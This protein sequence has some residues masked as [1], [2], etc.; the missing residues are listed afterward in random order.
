M[1]DKPKQ[2]PSHNAEGQPGTLQDEPKGE[3]LPTKEVATGGPE[4]PALE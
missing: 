2:D 4:P 1:P 3:N